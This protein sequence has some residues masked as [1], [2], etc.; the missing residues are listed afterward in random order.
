MRQTGEHCPPDLAVTALCINSI[1][2]KGNL[3]ELCC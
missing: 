2:C 1:L 3:S